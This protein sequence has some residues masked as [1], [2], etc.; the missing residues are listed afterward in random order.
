MVVLDMYVLESEKCIRVYVY[1]S[2]F[3]NDDG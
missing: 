3:F 1:V 2:F